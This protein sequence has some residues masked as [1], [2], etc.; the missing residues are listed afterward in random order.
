[1]AISRA[2]SYS[3]NA[4]AICRIILREFAAFRQV[5]TIGGQHAHAALD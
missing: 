3:A 5:V 2:F 4:P 1:L